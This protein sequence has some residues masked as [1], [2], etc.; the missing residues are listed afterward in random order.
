MEKNIVF[1]RISLHTNA[2][3]GSSVNGLILLN[4]QE[5]N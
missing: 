5:E 4:S 1:F 2:V 3:K